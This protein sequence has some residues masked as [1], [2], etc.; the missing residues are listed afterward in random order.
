MQREWGG[1]N[2]GELSDLNFEIKYCIDLEKLTAYSD[3]RE[4]FR[5]TWT[6]VHK[7]SLARNLTLLVPKFVQLIKV[8][9]Y[10]YHQ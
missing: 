3:S 2:C 5:S 9:R 8:T 1:L 6:P 10:G 4:I 7:L